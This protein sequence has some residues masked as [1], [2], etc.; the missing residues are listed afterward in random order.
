MRTA[1]E[2]WLACTHPAGCADRPAT[3]GGC[4]HRAANGSR[5][6][7]EAPAGRWNGDRHA[8]LQLCSLSAGR[9][10]WCFKWPLTHCKMRGL[11]PRHLRVR[12]EYSGNNGTFPG[13]RV[14]TGASRHIATSSREHRHGRQPAYMAPPGSSLPRH[15]HT[16]A[17]IGLRRFTRPGHGGNHRRI[18]GV[19]AGHTNVPGGGVHEHAAPQALAVGTVLAARVAVRGAVRAVAACSGRPWGF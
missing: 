6:R 2:G 15:G 12:H 13:V 9:D 7:L 8:G 11:G 14:S 17:V 3:S 19:A 10:K 18:R 4:G 5:G 1:R 16:V